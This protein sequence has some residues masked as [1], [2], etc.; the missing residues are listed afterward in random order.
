MNCWQLCRQV[1]TLTMNRRSTQ[2]INRQD[3]HCTGGAIGDAELNADV[4]CVVLTGAGKGFAP[5]ARVKG[6]A[7][8]V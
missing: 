8:V 4:R 3:E 5:A 7:R 2:L 6:M 1:L